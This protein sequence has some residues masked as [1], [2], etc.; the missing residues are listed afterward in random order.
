M[1]RISVLTTYRFIEIAGFPILTP[2]QI[3]GIAGFNILP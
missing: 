3:L 1:M 2:L